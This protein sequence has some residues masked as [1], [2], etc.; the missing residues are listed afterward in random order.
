MGVTR[1]SNNSII[2]D[3]QVNTR[4]IAKQYRKW[5]LNTIPPKKDEK[6][7]VGTWKDYQIRFS[8]DAEWWQW[9]TAGLTRIGIVCGTISSNLLVLD[10]DQGGKAFDAFKAKFSAELWARL[11][12][13][14]SPSGGYHIYVRCKEPVGGNETLASEPDANT[15]GKW[16]KLIETR[17]EGGFC[18]CAPSQGYS[19]IQGNFDNIPVLE[20]A[21]I[22]YL[23]DT[24]RSFDQKPQ[25]LSAPVHCIEAPVL[26]A[27]MA[28]AERRAISYIGAMPEAIEGCNGSADTL[29]V[30][31]KLHDFGLDKETAKRIFID[32]FN[33]R[34]KP[35][36]SEKEIDHKLD[37]AYNKP[38]KAAGCMLGSPTAPSDVTATPLYKWQPFPLEALPWSLRCFAED[39]SKSIGIDPASVAI[40]ALAVLSGLI[41][42]TFVLDVKRRHREYAM[43][44]C[45]LVAKSGFGKSPALNFSVHPIRQ[46]QADAHKAYNKAYAA[47]K[48]SGSQHKSASAQ[49]QTASAAP[50]EPVRLRYIVSNP[51]VEALLPIL[52]ENPY[53]ITLVRD[54]LAGFLKAMDRYHQGGKGDVQIF[55]EIHGGLPIS[56]DRKTGVQYLAVDTPSLAIVGGVQTEVLQSIIRKDPEFLTTGFA[57]RC[58]MAFPPPEPILWNDKEVDPAILSSYEGLINQILSYRGYLTH[59]NPGVVQLTPDAWVLIRDFQN[60]Q[61]WETLSTSD[62][63]VVSVLNKAGMHCARFALNL[64]I[65]KYAANGNIVPHYEH[66]SQDTMQ[67]AITLTEWFLNEAFRVYAMFNGSGVPED[68]V[69]IKVKEKIRQLGGK[70]THRELKMGIADFH[71]METEDI[72]DRLKEM[73]DAGLLSLQE[74]KAINGRLVKYYTLPTQSTLNT[75]NAQ[76]YQRY[77]WDKR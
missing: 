38:L 22:E 31:N 77:F 36:W 52:A 10:F 8:T 6:R 32:H 26:P 37:T 40:S 57:A 24:A 16:L 68:R 74:E 30:C 65:I 17:A 67:E 48:Q 5:G 71:N 2:L 53:G 63:G 69:A 42:R 1:M 34:C 3:A 20:S 28:E 62:A 43:L 19:L 41:G 66:V 44:W 21:E 64:H 35:E 13:E 14:Q 7:P 29:R 15:V 54:E 27:D 46:L 58:L 70:A 18:I 4:D 49:N 76:H 9:E 39:V 47:Y 45:M 73:V 61:A 72:K 60:Q 33:P 23:L 55:I 75:I 51:T 12:I 56:A 50:T 11:V 59:D 25:Q